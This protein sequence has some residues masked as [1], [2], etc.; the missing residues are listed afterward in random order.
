MADIIENWIN[1]LSDTHYVAGPRVNYSVFL[2]TKPGTRNHGAYEIINLKRPFKCKKCKKETVFHVF[3][4]QPGI[5]LLT[6]ELFYCSPE[7]M[8]D[9]HLKTPIYIS[10]YRDGFFVGYEPE[11]STIKVDPKDKPIFTNYILGNFHHMF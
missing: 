8:G 5:E 7:C 3:Y 10:K 6:R 11:D 9:E 2:S 1:G 4:I